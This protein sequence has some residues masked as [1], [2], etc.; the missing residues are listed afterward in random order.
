ML[1]TASKSL[2]IVAIL[3]AGVWGWWTWQQTTAPTLAA[4]LNVVTTSTTTWREAIQ[5]CDGI[6]NLEIENPTSSRIQI[7]NAPYVFKST[8]NA[9]FAGWQRLRVEE[10]FESGYLADGDHT[11]KRQ[12]R[13][14]RER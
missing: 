9:K 1:D 11:R 8:T 14:K 10:R 5:A 7:L 6:L 2:Q 13:R 12:P 3:V 4:A